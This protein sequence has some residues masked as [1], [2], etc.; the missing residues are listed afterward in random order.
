MLKKASS[1]LSLV[2]QRTYIRNAC[3]SACLSIRYLRRLSSSSSSS[4]LL[5]Y[6]DAKASW[7]RR[8]RRQSCFFFLSK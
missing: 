2:Y 8:R 7:R 4:L 5:V 6:D 1:S 3:L